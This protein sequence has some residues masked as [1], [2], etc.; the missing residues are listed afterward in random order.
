MNTNIIRNNHELNG[1]FDNPFQ[2]GFIEFSPGASV[3]AHF[4]YF[5]TGHDCSNIQIAEDDPEK[6]KAPVGTG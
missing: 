3:M 6:R 4:Y 2:Y 5:Y 1:F